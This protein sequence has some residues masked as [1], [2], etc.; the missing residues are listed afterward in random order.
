MALTRSNILRADTA[1]I[2]NTVS[3]VGFMGRGIA[4]QFKRAFPANFKAY[5]AACKRR[6]VEPGYMRVFETGQISN[7]RFIINFPTK[8][9]WRGKRRME[10]IEADSSISLLEIHELLYFVQEAGEPLRLRYVKA[11][12][13]PYAENL[14][15]VLAA[16]E[17]DLLSGDGDGGDDPEKPLELVPGAVNEARRFLS[18]RP[19]TS[20]RFDRVARLVEGFETPFGMELL[21]TVHW[22]VRYG[23]AATPRAITEAVHAWGPRKQMFSERQILLAAGRFVEEGWLPAPALRQP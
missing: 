10:D 3:C 16:V 19:E 23:G 1:A 13:G 20:A 21:S 5:E 2:V 9:H 8:R 18:G 15:H 17:G 7:P 6:E 14:R 12:L 4:A 22:V 11:P